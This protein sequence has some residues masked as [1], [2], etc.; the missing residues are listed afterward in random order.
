MARKIALV[1]SK[2]SPRGRRKFSKGRDSPEL[3]SRSSEET[4]NH[5]VHLDGPPN[6]TVAS[7][8]STSKTIKKSKKT[9]DTRSTTAT[10]GQMALSHNSGSF[11]KRRTFRPLSLEI[12]SVFNFADLKEKYGHRSILYESGEKTQPLEE[13][14]PSSVD[15]EALTSE[16][17]GKE[18]ATVLFDLD[19]RPFIN[20]HSQ[21][22]TSNSKDLI[23]NLWQHLLDNRSIQH[24]KTIPFLQDLIVLY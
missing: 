24:F 22:P 6:S 8:R 23:A 14:Q 21:L 12:N 5:A 3:D 15:Q 10:A 20:T 9:L 4:K 19:G 17:P 1:G 16:T 18:A 13:F 2:T 7:V 11:A